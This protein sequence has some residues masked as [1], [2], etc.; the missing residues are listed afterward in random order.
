MKSPLVSILIPVYNAGGYLRPA[1]ESILKQTY[2]N[3]EIIVINDGST[4]GCIE[5]IANLKD[6]RLRVIHKN[7]GGRASALNHGLQEISGTFYAIHDADDISY[8]ERIEKQVNYLQQHPGL[9]A[10]FTGYDLIIDGERVAPRFR[11]KDISQCR[12]DIDRMRMP[13]HDPTGM[14]RV[15]L[16]KGISYEETLWIGAAFDYI[17]RVGELHPMA[18]LGE[19][20]YSYRFHP[21]SVTHK[22]TDKRREMV[23]AVLRRACERRGQCFKKLFPRY[24][25]TNQQLSHRD[26][27]NGLVPHFMESVLDLRSANKT[28]QA[29]ET[30]LFCW[31]LHPSDPT[32]YKPLVY[33]FAPRRLIEYYRRSKAK[34]KSFTVK[35]N[36]NIS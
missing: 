1:V 31:R 32:Y 11:F 6:Q 3:L 21:C 22:F 18:V 23:Q 33:F 26:K 19:C 28:K 27:E 17:L 29:I 25:Q 8:P 34:H 13:S 4:D 16:V 14:F 9:A 35:N 7:N 24:P 5:T 10:V 30:A 12:Y 15:S 20:L 36:R 2:S